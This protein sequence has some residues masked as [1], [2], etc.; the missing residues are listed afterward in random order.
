MLH[1]DAGFSSRCHLILRWIAKRL[2]T[3]VNL[4]ERE[5]DLNQS[6]AQV[7]E[8]AQTSWPK[9]VDIEFVFI[10][11]YKHCICTPCHLRKYGGK[12]LERLYFFYHLLV[13]LLIN[14]HC[15]CVPCLHLRNMA[16][17]KKIERLYLFDPL[18]TRFVF[19]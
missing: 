7:N 10:C 2:K 11:I 6:T 14:K 17:K 1:F 4:C 19:T 16:L 8:G 18:N 15:I 12:R 9:I 5:L 3:C 13:L